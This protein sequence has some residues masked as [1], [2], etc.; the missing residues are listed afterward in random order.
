MSTNINMTETEAKQLIRQ[1]ADEFG[2][3]EL[4]KTAPII[5]TNVRNSVAHEFCIKD[6]SDAA[7]SA[8]KALPFGNPAREYI[9]NAAGVNDDE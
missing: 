7:L 9:F 8:A 3:G 6:P 1:I 2:I 4:S 5:L